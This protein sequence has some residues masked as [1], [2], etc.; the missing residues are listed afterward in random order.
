MR[1]L[2]CTFLLS[3]VLTGVDM[4]APE[5]PLGETR[6]TVHTLGREDIFAG[7][8]AD[9]MRRLDRAERNIE[10]LLKDRPAERANLLAW[11]GGAV[12]YRAVIAHEAKKTDEFNRQL[13]MARDAFAEAAALKSGNDGVQAIT[14]GSF[15][16]FSDR[17]PEAQRE[18]AWAQ[19]YDAY[20]A[21]WKDQSAIVLKLPVHHR[22]ELLSGMAVSAHRT[23]R[24]EQSAEF[25]D[26]MIEQLPETSYQAAA[27]AWKANPGSV[28]LTCRS[29][30]APGRLADRLAVL[31]KGSLR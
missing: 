29:C 7:F 13:A 27:Q 31:N 14:G 11:K 2:L 21:L 15:V 19:A 24:T 17:L 5:P 28:G 8:Q 18:A 16:L 23:G 10:I 30:H 3:A 6:L 1:I 20:S 9:D 4:Q 25:V 26:K 22:G 12:L